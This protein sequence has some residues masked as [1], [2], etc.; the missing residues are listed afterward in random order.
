MAG[1][2]LGSRNP[3]GGYALGPE[4]TS[5]GSGG[6]IYLLENISE[7]FVCFGP[8]RAS[9]LFARRGQLLGPRGHTPRSRKAAGPASRF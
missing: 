9:G 2:E 6:A 5:A 8:S 3:K 1:V 4:L 7:C